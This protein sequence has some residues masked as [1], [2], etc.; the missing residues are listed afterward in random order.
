LPLVNGLR[1]T[2]EWV[3]GDQAKG[4]EAEGT[5]QRLKANSCQ[6]INL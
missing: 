6:P 2:G 1:N 5:K 3:N 4:T